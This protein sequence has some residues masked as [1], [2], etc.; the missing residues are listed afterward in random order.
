MSEVIPQHAMDVLRPSLLGLEQHVQDLVCTDIRDT[1]LRTQMMENR[2]IAGKILDA[3]ITKLGLPADDALG[4]LDG[5]PNL[6]T[7]LRM[8][9][10][11]LV[12]VLGLAREA[13]RVARHLFDKTLAPDLQ[14]IERE[15]L[16]RTLSYRALTD[17]CPQAPL[18]H[19]D[20]VEA[21][22]AMLGEWVW[23]LPD[24]IKG[25]VALALNVMGAEC[26]PQ[27]STVDLANRVISELPEAI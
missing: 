20:V 17:H 6:L 11:D 13:Q 9:R 22:N 8:D 27:K 24:N 16:R 2:R 21:G 5:Q 23:S 15:R 26:V 19:K 7:A 18:T 1:L 12:L 14:N 25:R 10:S 3:T 4:S